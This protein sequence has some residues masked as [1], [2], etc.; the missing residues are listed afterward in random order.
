MSSEQFIEIYYHVSVFC[1]D[2]I[3]IHNNG[4]FWLFQ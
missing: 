4:S 2:E 3:E 1:G